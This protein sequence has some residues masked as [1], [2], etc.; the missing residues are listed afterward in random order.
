MESTTITLS[1]IEEFKI[2]ALHWAN[3]FKVV[4]LLDS[5]GYKH[6]RYSSMEWQ[7]AVDERK[8]LFSAEPGTFNELAEYPKKK[9]QTLYGFLNYDLKNEFENLHSENADRLG[10]P[11]LYFFEP[12]YFLEIRNNKLTVNRNYP[13]TFELLESIRNF[14]VPAY[15]SVTVPIQNRTSRKEY[16]KNVEYIKERISEGDFYELNYCNEFYAENVSISPAH[17]F[18][19]LNNRAKAPF[20]C[21]FKHFDNFLLCASPERFLKKN[22][23]KVISQPIK[24]TISRG[25]NDQENLKYQ[26]QLLNS[27]KERAENVM[28]VDLVRNDLAHSSK[29]GSVEV[30]E[31]FGIYEFETVNHMI[32]TVVSVSKCNNPFDIIQTCFPMGSMTG[33]PKIEV[34]KHIDKLENFKRGLYS[35]SVGYITPDGNFD[36]N[37]VIRSIFYNAATGY[38]SVPVGS[39]I[40]YD[41][42]AVQE[43]DELMMKIK[44]QLEILSAKA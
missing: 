3:Q 37:V 33:A 16:L 31:L 19:L 20:T 14:E 34:M 13:E 15:T 12:R 2:K 10:F 6:D 32:S 40:T 5:N 39:A 23:E 17:V 9:K 22:G 25:I 38:V 35:G 42:D 43:W 1:D 11:L 18:H 21:F 4:C 41:S 8:D 26:Q 29:T 30:E 24:G 44:T 7:L 27:E 36:L 28:I